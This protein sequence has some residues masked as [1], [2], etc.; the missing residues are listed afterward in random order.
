M[1]LIKITFLTLAA[2]A[3]FASAHVR[4]ME[5][6]Y[7]FPPAYQLIANEHTASAQ[8]LAA[9]MASTEQSG[10]NPVLDSLCLIILSPRLR[11]LLSTK[12]TIVDAQQENIQA[13]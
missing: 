8:P 10:S 13:P 6:G 12:Q 2:L 11:S 7:T 3:L 9:A 5:L 4:C 1:T